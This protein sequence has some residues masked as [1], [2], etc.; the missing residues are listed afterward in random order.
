MAFKKSQFS[1]FPG[2]LG[3]CAVLLLAGACSGL[4]P[5][6]GSSNGTALTNGDLVE[7]S[8]PIPD[9]SSSRAAT[10]IGLGTPKEYVTYYEAIFFEPD[11]SHIS[12]K[13]IASGSA[14]VGDEIIKVA[15]PANEA[16][17]DGSYQGYEVL[18]LAGS[19]ANK[20]PINGEKV[21]LGSGY[22]KNVVVYRRQINRVEV[23]MY[24]LDV[25]LEVTGMKKG[26]PPVSGGNNATPLDIHKTADDGLHYVELEKQTPDYATATQNAWYNNGGYYNSLD[27]TITLK[28]LDPLLHASNG[29]DGTAIAS[30]IF[31]DPRVRIEP[32]SYREFTMTPIIFTPTTWASVSPGTLDPTNY[33]AISSLSTGIVFSYT[34]VARGSNLNDPLI[35]PASDAAGVFYFNYQYYPFGKT[36]YGSYWNIRNRLIWTEEGY[37]GGGVAFLFGNAGTEWV[38]VIPQFVP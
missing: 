21:L 6:D 7:V 9:I 1:T 8:I 37:Y 5:D 12:G 27:V 35:I 26:V 20:N 36:D 24:E 13:I 11:P 10:A 2:I 19:H 4:L 17:I 14:L 31:A 16:K 32:I 15:V 30:S 3:M 25:S 33:T 18:V 34:Q 28:N 29:G 38:E 23:K 22:K